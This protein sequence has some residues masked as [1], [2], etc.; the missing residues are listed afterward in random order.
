MKSNITLE[1]ADA[2]FFRG[3]KPFTMSVDTFAEGFFPPLPSTVYGAICSAVY[4]KHENLKIKNI[5]LKSNSSY[6][7]PLPKDLVVP[8]GKDE[9]TETLILRELNNFSN[10]EPNFYLVREGSKKKLSKKKILLHHRLLKK[11]LNGEGKE[12]LIVSSLDEYISSETK[13]GIGRNNQTKLSSD[14]M[15]YR[16]IMTRLEHSSKKSICMALEI[17]HQEC[18]NIKA[19]R[20]G[21]EN[22]IASLLTDNSFIPMDCPKIEGTMFKIY[23]STP[24]IFKEGGIPIGLFKEHGLSFLTAV[25]DKP[26]PVGG[27]DF[28]NKQPKPMVK[29]V[30]AGSVYYVEAKTEEEANQIARKIHNTSISNYI[31]KVDDNLEFDSKKQG[32]GIAFIGKI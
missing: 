28:V 2:L 21:G 32:F 20:L 23:L 6:L 26:V 25:L 18:F 10:F 11:Y 8:K 31:Y 24:A 13:I 19:V 17:E 22:R 29:V 14:G 16:T 3:G 27:W 30:P 15:L 1:A 9:K 12:G 7:F 4:P 5:C